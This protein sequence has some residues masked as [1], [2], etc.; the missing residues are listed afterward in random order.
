MGAGFEPTPAAISSFRP[1]LSGVVHFLTA[2]ISPSLMS[3]VTLAHP[4]VMRVQHGDF[5]GREFAFRYDR[6]KDKE[7]VLAEQAKQSDW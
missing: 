3:R 2:P 4:I 5:L 7:T 6:R 1:K